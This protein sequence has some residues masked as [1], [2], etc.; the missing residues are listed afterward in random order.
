MRSKRR[1]GGPTS[2]ENLRGRDDRSRA[3]AMRLFKGKVTPSSCG[4]VNW[5]CL[6]TTGG[7]GRGEIQLVLLNHAET[8]EVNVDS[9][10]YGPVVPTRGFRRRGRGHLY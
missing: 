2:V 7:K 8:T 4:Q 1:S 3:V 10:E 6:E 9:A 5:V